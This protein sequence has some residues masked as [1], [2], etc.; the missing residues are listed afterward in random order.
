MPG[1][2]Q[3]TAEFADTSGHARRVTALVRLTRPTRQPGH[4]PQGVIRRTACHH[5]PGP[6]EPPTRPVGRISPQGVIRQ[7]ACRH[8]PDRINL[9]PA[10]RISPQGVIRQMAWSHTP[11]KNQTKDRA[12]EHLPGLHL[13][14]IFPAFHLPSAHPALPGQRTAGFG[15]H[16]ALPFPVVII[17]EIHHHPVTGALQ[18]V[19]TRCV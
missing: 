19:G 11:G 18:F 6:H 17:V 15:H 14:V 13:P 3:T 2:R 8:P 4:S 9:Q 7:L 10:G 12:P 5:P 16:G 1:R